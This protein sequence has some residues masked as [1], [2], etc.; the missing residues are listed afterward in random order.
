[1]RISFLILN[2]VGKLEGMREL[3]FKG[4]QDNQMVIL[5]LLMNKQFKT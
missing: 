4:G 1:M 2:E 5:S 3:K